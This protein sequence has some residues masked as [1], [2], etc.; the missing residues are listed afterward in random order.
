MAIKPTGQTPPSVLG[1]QGGKEIAEC[2]RSL[3][4]TLWSNMHVSGMQLVRSTVKLC[5]GPAENSNVLSHA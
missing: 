3:K 5:F 4:K 1:K 2:S